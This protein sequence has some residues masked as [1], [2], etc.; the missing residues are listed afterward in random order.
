MEVFCRP[1]N[2]KTAGSY[3]AASATR[4]EERK[5]EKE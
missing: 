3:A 4:K 5:N 2:A 1:E